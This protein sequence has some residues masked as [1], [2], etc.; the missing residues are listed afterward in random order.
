M[1]QQMCSKCG[2]RPAVLFI[3]KMEDG[4]VVPEGLCIKCAREMNVG[5]INQMIDQL[6]ISDEELEQASE[7]MSQFMENMQ[8]FDFGSVGDM[9]D[10]DNA[11][12]A[13]TL[14]FAS[15]FRQ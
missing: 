13:Q 11:E 3:Q 15:L 2:V 7:Q 14:P 9:L 12:G 10:P 6:G 8:D 1:K 4:K 5:S